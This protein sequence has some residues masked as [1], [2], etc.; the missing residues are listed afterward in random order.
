ME[1]ALR[2]FRVYEM[3]VY[4][5][6]GVLALWHLRK[7]ILAWMELR[8]ALFGMER[9][10]A[11][12]RLNRSATMLVL[13]LIMAV[14]EFTL[15]YLVS[16]SVPGAMPLPSPTLDL[17]AT[18]TITLPVLQPA[19]L[20]TQTTPSPTP[21]EQPVGEGCTP[22][23]VI[24]SAPKDGQQVSGVVTLE[25]T[26]DT[27][28]FGFFSYEIARPGETIWLPV[29]VGQLPVR[30]GVLGTWDTSTLAPG[31]YMLRLV[32]TDSE[33]NA[34]TPCVIKVQVVAPP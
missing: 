2:F 10:S 19:V 34:L 20:E 12:T 8:G 18:P 31:E 21:I 27:P 16:P 3:W 24:F 33:S 32:V 23:Q 29:Q 14:A 4:L 9:E 17:L 22:G 28:N 11:Q 25:G 5:G 26:A 13:W 15:V 6:L 1:E 30:E 7:F